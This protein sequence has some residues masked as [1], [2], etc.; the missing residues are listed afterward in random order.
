MRCVLRSRTIPSLIRS[1]RGPGGLE[2]WRAGGLEGWRV[3]GLEGWRAGGLEK[4]K[5]W[6]G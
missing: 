3:G 1:D 6:S 2:G 4:A 5:D